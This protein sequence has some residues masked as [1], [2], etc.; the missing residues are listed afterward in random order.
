MKLFINQRN[1]DLCDVKI[2]G[3]L[4]VTPDSFFDGGNYCTLHKAI[5][6]THYMIMHG[7]TFIDVGGE[8]TRPGFSIISEEEEVERVIPIVR[9]ISSRFDT[10][11]SINTSSALVIRESVK[12]GAHLINDVRAL[13]SKE[14]MKAAVYCALPICLV[15]N[16]QERF[17]KMRCFPQYYNIVEEVNNYFIKKISYCESLGISRDKLLLDPGFGFG[18]NLEHNYQLL[19]NLKFFHHFNLPILVGMSRK[20]MILNNYQRNQYH[21]PHQRLIGSIAAVVIS[22]MKGAHIVRVHDVK[23]TAEALC[24]VNLMYS[25]SE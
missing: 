5:D 24:I 11:I 8:S 10:L 18:K 3:I 14:A 12:A 9:A 21:A 23:E 2:M 13:S 15:H 19:L 25:N 22:S 4:N 6:H 20:S 17:Q 1:L 16:V 7:A